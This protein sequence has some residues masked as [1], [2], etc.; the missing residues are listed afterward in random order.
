MI[1]KDQVGRITALAPKLAQSPR[2]KVIQMT[3]LGNVP[4]TSMLFQRVKSEKLKNWHFSN[5][6]CGSTDRAI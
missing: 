2:I 3:I 6:R 5:G 1:F 4:K